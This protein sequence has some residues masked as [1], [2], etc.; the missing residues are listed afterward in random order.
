MAN[1]NENKQDTDE[2]LTELDSSELDMVSGGRGKICP[3]L[4]IEWGKAT[5]SE[6]VA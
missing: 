6:V 1:D 5:A 3:F 4:Y 2:V